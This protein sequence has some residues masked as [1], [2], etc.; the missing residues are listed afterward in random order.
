[1]KPLP[2]KALR[3]V[4]GIFAVLCKNPLSASIPALKKYSLQAL[5]LLPQTT[6][7]IL[8]EVKMVEENI[9]QNS[10]RSILDL[11][12]TQSCNTANKQKDSDDEIELVAVIT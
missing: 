12:Q 6:I 5:L 1:M 2:I 9:R 4:T 11:I 10:E 8:S 3:W 7:L